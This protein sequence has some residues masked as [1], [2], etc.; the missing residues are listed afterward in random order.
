MRT[1]AVVVLGVTGMETA[2]NP[3]VNIVLFV[4]A[5]GAGRSRVAAAYFNRVA[6]P[7]W[8]ALS[9]G[10]EPQDTLGT[11]AASMLAGSA[12]ETWL[13]RA[14][15]RPISAVPSP[16]RVIAIDCDVPSPGAERWDLESH[17]FDQAMS[18]E[19]CARTELLAR[20]L[21]DLSK[22]A[23]FSVN[24]MKNSSAS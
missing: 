5:H 22:W 10:V 15:P 18:T 19:L 11:R 3:M 24:T 21:A 16:A 1:L 23:K 6:P 12:A 13:D 2:V 14:R 4:C 8:V 17:Q 9:A 20:D 7:G